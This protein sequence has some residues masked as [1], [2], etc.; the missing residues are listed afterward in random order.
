MDIINHLQILRQELC[1]ISNKGG[2]D[3]KTE[4]QIHLAI[5]RIDLLIEAL[6]ELEENYQS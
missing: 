2:I 4:G 6:S 5:S 3:K 1:E